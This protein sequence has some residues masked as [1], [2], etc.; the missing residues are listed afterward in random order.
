M[1]AS[2]P[3]VKWRRLLL[4]PRYAFVAAATADTSTD[5]SLAGWGEAERINFCCIYLSSR[6]TEELRRLY[7]FRRRKLTLERLT[8]IT[9]ICIWQIISRL[10]NTTTQRRAARE[11]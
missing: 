3:Q 8:G 10:V 5:T 11:D 4:L 2:C 9:C 7:I 1:S 6:F